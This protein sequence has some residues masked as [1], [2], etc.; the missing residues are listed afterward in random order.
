MR[1]AADRKVFLPRSVNDAVAILRRRPGAVIFAG[2]SE[3]QILGPGETT[4]NKDIIALHNIEELR[5]IFRSDRMLE[6]GAMVTLERLSRLEDNVLPDG[7]NQAIHTLPHAP[8][9][10]I[11]TLGGNLLVHPRYFSTWHYLSLADSRVE[12]RRAGGGRWIPVSRLRDGENHP[13]L[14]Q[15][16]LTKIRIPV[17]VWNRQVFRRYYSRSKDADYG[18]CALASIQRG[19]IEDL[20]IAFVFGG[21]LN[22]RNRDADATMVGRRLPVSS[23]ELENYLARISEDWKEHPGWELSDQ[24][25]R[26]RLINL[27]AWFVHSLTKS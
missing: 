11:A 23:K 14:H 27:S 26:E 17:N 1:I 22:Y 6:I 12:L 8:V 5:R 15:E 3:F 19:I 2:G 10:S 9:R 16:L 7:L 21:L 4:I 20:R 18:F 13:Q 24:L 25:M